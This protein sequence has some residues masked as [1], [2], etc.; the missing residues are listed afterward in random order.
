[1]TIALRLLRVKWLAAAKSGLLAGLLLLLLPQGVPW[2]ALNFFSGAVMGRTSQSSGPDIG[3]IIIH[4]AISLMYGII[5]AMIIKDMKS[6]WVIPFG[7]LIGLVLYFLNLICVKMWISH[8]A[9]HEE[10][11][12]LTH[13]IFGLFAAAIYGGLTHRRWST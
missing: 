4:L 8:F 3:R 11:V 6:W 10:Q 9:G 7:G 1:M 5:I 2:A 13:V 12:A